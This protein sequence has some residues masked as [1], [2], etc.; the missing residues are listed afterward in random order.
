M[1]GHDV[2][3]TRSQPGEY[4]INRRNVGRS[5]REGRHNHGRRVGDPE[6][7]EDD[8]RDRD[9][10]RGGRERRSRGARVLS[11]LGRQALEGGCQRQA[12]VLWSRSI[13]RLTTGL[14]ARFPRHEPGRTPTG[15]STS[16]DLNGNMMAVD[17]ATGDCDGSE[18]S[19]RTRP[20]SSR[21]RRRAWQQALHR[22]SR[23]TRRHSRGRRPAMLHFP[24]Q[25][26]RARPA[27]RGASSGRRFV[28]P[29]NSGVPG[30]FAG[31]AFV[32]P[33]AIDLENGLM[34]AAAGKLYTQPDARHGVSRG[35]I[36]TGGS[37]ACFP[38]RRVLQLGRL[39]SICAPAQPRWSF[40][41]AGAD[42]RELACGTCR[43]RHVVP[44]WREQL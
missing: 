4:T 10:D 41:G 9:G 40:R 13:S 25:H 38:A 17:A 23:R 37:E 35:R 29:D 34:Y 30:G 8:D 12:T 26:D 20:P 1:I 18:S 36:R 44:A 42:A 14:R 27:R 24:R 39:P 33:P 28:L 15:W 7:V 3:D 22:R 43:R 11:R 5:N 2:S 31:G 6:V 32:N 16:A 19:I 21:H